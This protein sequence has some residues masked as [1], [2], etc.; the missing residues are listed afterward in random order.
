MLPRPKSSKPARTLASSTAPVTLP[1]GQYMHAHAAPA[2]ADAPAHL[3][4]SL[5]GANVKATPEPGTRQT[6]I[7]RLRQLEA[8]IG[9]RRSSIYARMSPTTTSYDPSFP[10]PVSLGSPMCQ[11]RSAVGWLEHEIESWLQQRSA[12]RGGEKPSGAELSKT[13][14]CSGSS[15]KGD[16]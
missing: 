3:R 5:E 6:K 12:D 1:I 15:G 14:I 10:R 4:V 13:N 11:R 2:L 16:K 7:L 9:L 8:R